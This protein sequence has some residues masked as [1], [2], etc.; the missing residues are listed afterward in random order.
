MSQALASCV[1]IVALLAFAGSGRFR[2]WP[3]KDFGFDRTPEQQLAVSRR[4]RVAWLA[5][6]AFSL[7]GTG[8]L[9]F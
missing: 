1:L 4:L 3:L 8:V 6:I 9:K 7:I 5:V 2:V